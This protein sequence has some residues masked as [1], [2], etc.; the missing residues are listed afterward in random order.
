MVITQHWPRFDRVL[1]I[2]KDTQSTLFIDIEEDV[3]YGY[4]ETAWLWNLYVKE[5]YREQGIATK[6]IKDAEQAAKKKGCVATLLKWNELMSAG[7]T[8]DWYRR[9]GYTEK[10]VKEGY[11]IYEKIL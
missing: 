7:F 2:D 9:L 8:K 10:E 1:I 11:I 6:L 5:E 3:D 4:R